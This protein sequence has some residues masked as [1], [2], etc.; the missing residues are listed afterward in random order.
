M[1]TAV[2]SDDTHPALRDRAQQAM[3]DW[4]SLIVRIVEKGIVRGELPPTVKPEQVATILI[5]T[6][7]GAVMLT[8]LYGDA[9]YLQQ[10]IDH[11]KTHVRQL[12][13]SG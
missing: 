9:S 11:L 4:R 10:A 2:E 1:N 7:E 12:A 5:A 13:L 3:N 8:K 6:I